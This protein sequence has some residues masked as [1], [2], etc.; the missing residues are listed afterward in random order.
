MIRLEAKYIQFQSLAP[1]LKFTSSN[2]GLKQASHSNEKSGNTLPTSKK[3]QVHWY[4][5]KDSF[6]ASVL[7]PSIKE[8]SGEMTPTPKDTCIVISKSNYKIYFLHR[9]MGYC[10][11]HDNK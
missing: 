4:W 11:T 8:F 3:L 7:P 5:G 10:S 2:A 6:H 9:S 1:A